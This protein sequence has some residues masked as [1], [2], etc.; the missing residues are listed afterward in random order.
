MRA[1]RGSIRVSD[2]DAM[3]LPST[4]T[5]P[6][7]GR[8][9][10]HTSLSSTLLPDAAGPMMPTRAP[11]AISRSTPV[12]TS[13]WPKLLVTPRS[14]TAGTAGVEAGTATGGS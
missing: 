1:R 14:W 5:A 10:P 3:S 13:R 7:S 6:S 11:C 8:S 9:S 12:S 4:I 2:H